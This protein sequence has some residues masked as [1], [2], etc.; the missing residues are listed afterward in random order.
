[1]DAQ[2]ARLVDQTWRKYKDTPASQRFLVAISGIPGSGD[3]SSQ[4]TVIQ[5]PK[6]SAY[7]G[8][9]T[10]ASLVTRLLNQR[11]SQ[12][13]PGCALQSIAAFVPMDGYHLSRA[14]LSAMPDPANARARRGAAFT[15]DDRAFLALVNKLREPLCP[16]STTIYA[17]SFDHAT[18]D[19][20]KDDIPIPTSA[21]IVILEGNYLSL[22][23]GLWKDAA[24]LM[25]ELWFVEVDFD[26]ARRRL[27]TR[28]VKSGVTTTKEEAEQRVTDNDLVNGEEIVKDRLQVQEVVLSLEDDGWKPGS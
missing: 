21:R 17:P 4:S 26:T 18:K 3:R 19:P 23:K 16:E 13:E 1:M 8:K 14:Q 10:L 20:V 15:F 5:S 6:Y 27:V 28:H 11:H 7:S 9:T 12:E 24:Q 2:I 25:N 22:N